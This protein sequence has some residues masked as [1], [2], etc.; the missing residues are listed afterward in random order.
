MKHEAK[1]KGLI[2]IK[3]HAWDPDGNIT[4]VQVRIFEVWYNAT[5]DSGNGSW[6]KWSLIFNTSILKDDEYRVVAISRD[7]GGKLGDFGIWII[8][9]NSPEPKENHWPYVNITQPENEATV[10]GI[11]TIKGHAWDPDGN[12]TRVQVKIFEVWYNTTDD[13]GNSS[14]YKWS[15]KFNTSI[16][17]DDEYSVVAISRD[18]GGKLGD[19]GIWIIV[20]NAPKEKENHRPFVNITAPEHEANVSGMVKINGF[21]W[22]VDGNVSYVQIRIG[23]KYYNATDTSGNNTWYTW[24]FKWNTTGLENGEYRIGVIVYDGNLYED[25][26]VVVIL[27]NAKSGESKDDEGGNK[28][29]P[30]PGF[31]GA[32]PFV[33]LIATAVV[34][35]FFRSAR[36]NRRTK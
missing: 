28:R 1:V 26:S 34:V 25:T 7:N 14:W 35:G 30:I 5:D 3:G 32:L 12:I 19:Y 21:S 10:K 13:S 11:I 31:D 6:Y 23:E 4:Q 29:R 16:L 18:N 15:L 24:E 22:D 9:R 2:T 17:K 36:N 27:N 20:K 33:A 8:V